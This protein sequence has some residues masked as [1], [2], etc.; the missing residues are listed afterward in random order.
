L[1]VL[2]I[3]ARVAVALYLAALVMMLIAAMLAWR[4]GGPM[5]PVRL[6]VILAL[7]LALVA[8]GT[9]QLVGINATLSSFLAQTIP[10]FGWWLTLL[11]LVAVFFSGLNVLKTASLAKGTQ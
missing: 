1:N 7:L 11:G 3:G 2:G 4:R 5:W 9:W 8:I 6:S 10:W